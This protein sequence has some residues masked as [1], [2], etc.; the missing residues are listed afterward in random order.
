LICTDYILTLF[1]SS[2]GVYRVHAL[3]DYTDA[4]LMRDL[5]NAYLIKF[6]N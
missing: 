4:V 1:T 2:F 6:D 3:W 5:S